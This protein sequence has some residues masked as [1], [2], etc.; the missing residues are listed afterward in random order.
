ML[1][2]RSVD[3]IRKRHTFAIDLGSIPVIQWTEPDEIK[4]YDELFNQKVEELEA[5]D[6]DIERIIRNPDENMQIALGRANYLESRIYV[7]ELKFHKHLP[8]GKVQIQRD[9]IQ[10]LIGI[11]RGKK[12][13]AGDLNQ[14]M[15]ECVFQGEWE[16]NPRIGVV[17]IDGNETKLRLRKSLGYLLRYLNACEYEFYKQIV[18]AQLDHISF[19]YHMLLQDAEFRG[20][21]VKPK[22]MDERDRFHYRFE[23][24]LDRIYYFR[25]RDFLAEC[26]NMW[27]FLDGNEYTKKYLLR[28][29]DIH[30][31]LK[32]HY[33]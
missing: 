7:R 10:E 20:E 32:H 25:A 23:N 31:N 26:T 28:M 17:E 27:N 18:N 15:N 4:N 12:S 11:A 1:K 3:T 9:M 29:E 21:K 16:A 2:L 30:P 33:S 24:V 22:L 5:F 13:I 8:Q 6:K 14:E 19:C